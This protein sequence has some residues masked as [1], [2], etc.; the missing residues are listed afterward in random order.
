LVKGLQGETKKMEGIKL[1]RKK[2]ESGN[3]CFGAS[4]TFTDPLITEALSDSIDFLWID[5]EHTSM[6]PETLSS[7]LL[8]ARSKQIPSLVRIS[9]NSTPFI[10]P[11]LDSGADGIIAPQVRSA[12]EIR[13]VVSDCRYPPLG[14]RG[15]G[16][17]VPSNYARD[18]GKEYIDRANENIFVVAQIETAEAIEAIDDIVAIPGLDSLAFG[19]HDLAFSLG[20]FGEVEHPE[21]VAAMDMVIDKARSAGLFIGSGLGAD[22]DYAYTLIKR[23][24]QWVQMGCDFHYITNHIDQIVSSVYSRLGKD[25]D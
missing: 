18:G 12:N 23:G 5:L 4:V 8:A 13:Q 19:P 21:V 11:V 15:Y 16:P 14:H 1:F 22:P 2:L 20:F 9:G 10:K 25:R 6:N 17:R 7:H 3:V 24:V